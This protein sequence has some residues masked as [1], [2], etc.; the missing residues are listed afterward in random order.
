MLNTLHERLRVGRTQK[1][2]WTRLTVY[3]SAQVPCSDI[4]WQLE[5]R[6]NAQ[7]AMA[8]IM[9]SSGSTPTSA[10]QRRG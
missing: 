7:N 10:L 5:K 1:V 4:A 2:N 8:G 3:T 9:A 6:E